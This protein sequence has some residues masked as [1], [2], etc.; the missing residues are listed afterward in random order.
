MRSW[1][2]GDALSEDVVGARAAGLQPIWLSVDQGVP[3]PTAATR[4]PDWAS[5]RRLYDA[6]RAPAE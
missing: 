3:V 5:L 4:I 2:V 1:F 6:T